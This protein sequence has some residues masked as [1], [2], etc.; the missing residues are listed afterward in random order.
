MTVTPN[1]FCGDFYKKKCWG[2]DVTRFMHH[3]FTSI[4][5]GIVTPF[6]RYVLVKSRQ[7]N[8]LMINYLNR[9]KRNKMFVSR[10]IL[11]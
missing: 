8:H 5:E 6:E 11:S 1:D 4:K 2:W 10:R 9:L 3:P 7:E